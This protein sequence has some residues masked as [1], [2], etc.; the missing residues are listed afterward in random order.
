MVCPYANLIDKLGIFFVNLDCYCMASSN[1]GNKRS[2]QTKVGVDLEK[3]ANAN[4]DAFRD[5]PF[6][7]KG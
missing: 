2:D 6:Y 4:R 5:C 3:C 7:K 1:L